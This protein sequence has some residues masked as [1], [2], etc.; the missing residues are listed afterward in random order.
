VSPR[1]FVYGTLR[2]GGPRAS[3]LNGCAFL[4]RHTLA[5]YRLLDLGAFP[6]AVPGDGG[7]VGELYELRDEAIL[8]F[9][10]AVEGVDDAPPLYRR[11]EVAVDGAPA[12]M[13]VYAR[14]SLRARPIA[15]GDWLSR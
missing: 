8:E 12:W 6:G 13:Y 14:E 15:S 9:L 2:K 10:D 5:G 4:G 1:V 3:F 11:R 7:V